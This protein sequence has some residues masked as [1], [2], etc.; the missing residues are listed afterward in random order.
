M[1]ISKLLFF[2]YLFSQYRGYL[3]LTYLVIKR[4]LSS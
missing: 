2:R 3:K 1:L 4:L